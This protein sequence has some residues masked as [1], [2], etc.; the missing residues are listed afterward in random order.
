MAELS[1]TLNRAGIAQ[2]SFDMPDDCCYCAELAGHRTDFHR[3]YPDIASRILMIDRSFVVMP[4]LGQLAPGHLLLVPRRHATAFG[5]LD[6]LRR[7]TATTVYRA[8]RK[9]LAQRYGSP[10]V[11]FEHGSPPDAV[12]GG[13]G[14]VHAHVHFV[15]LASRAAATPASLGGT[16]NPAS[17]SWIDEAA[18][19][20]REGSSYLLWHVDGAAPL[21]SL[22]HDV[23]S[24]YLRRHVSGLLGTADWDWRT[25]GPEQSLRST[26]NEVAALVGDGVFA[27]PW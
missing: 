14:I 23:P 21:L 27:A 24:Q 20:T 7:Q 16:W 26:M 6:A 5:G 9:S 18:R 25:A 4:S 3:L 22:A 13:C 10:V 19:L 17:G 11:C 15:P 8:L 2:T 12:S 1:A